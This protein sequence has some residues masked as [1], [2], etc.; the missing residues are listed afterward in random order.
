LK[1]EA[2]GSSEDLVLSTKIHRVTSQ[3]TVSNLHS[4]S[5]GNLKSH[6]NYSCF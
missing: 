2:A 4:F 1:M 6:L 3:K 5:C